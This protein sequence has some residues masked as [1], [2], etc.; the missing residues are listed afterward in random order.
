MKN[1]VNYCPRPIIEG[2]YGVLPARVVPSNIVRPAYVSIDIFKVLG[3]SKP[4]YGIHEGPAVI[5]NQA[6][7]ES[8]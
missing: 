8:N 1:N 5:H 2:Q 7:I 4:I 6:T 3:D